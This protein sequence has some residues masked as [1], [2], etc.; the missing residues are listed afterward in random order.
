MLVEVEVLRHAIFEK[1]GR[2][3]EGLPGDQQKSSYDADRLMRENCEKLFTAHLRLPQLSRPEVK[4]LVETFSGFRRAMADKA[5][6]LTKAKGIINAKMNTP[7]ADSVLV[8]PG[9]PGKPIPVALTRTFSRQS[10][11]T[12]SRT[13]FRL[14]F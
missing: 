12:L 11:G 7:P 14:F 2:L 9:K 3:A 10:A 6:A 13:G 5:E 4:N 8:K 1:Y